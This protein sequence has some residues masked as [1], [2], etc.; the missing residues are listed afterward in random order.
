MTEALSPVPPHQSEELKRWGQPLTIDILGHLVCLVNLV[1]LA[2][3]K[4]ES[5]NIFRFTSGIGFS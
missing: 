5:K 4:V 3:V 1:C 2:K